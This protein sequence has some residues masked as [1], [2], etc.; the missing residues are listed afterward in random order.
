MKDAGKQSLCRIVAQ[1]VSNIVAQHL[2]GVGKGCPHHAP[3]AP[4]VAKKMFMSSAAMPSAEGMSGCRG[5]GISV[6]SATAPTAPW[7]GS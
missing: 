6:A 2:C 7:I 3:A 4:T 5:R 1:P